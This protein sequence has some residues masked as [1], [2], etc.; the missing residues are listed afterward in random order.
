MSEIRERGGV[1]VYCTGTTRMVLVYP[2]PGR[3]PVSTIT[4]SP[5]LKNPRALPEYHRKE[6]KWH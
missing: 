1:E 4:T 6:K 3:Q 2:E 5:G